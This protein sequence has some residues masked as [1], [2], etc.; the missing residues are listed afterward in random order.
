M[1]ILMTEVKLFKAALKDWSRV[2]FG[3][4]HQQISELREN[5]QELHSKLEEKPFV[6]AIQQQIKAAKNTHNQ[7]EAFLH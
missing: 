5:L 3:K 1:S 7:K 6:A 4:S 2:E